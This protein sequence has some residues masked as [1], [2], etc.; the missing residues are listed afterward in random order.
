MPGSHQS[1]LNKRSEWLSDKARQW[2]VLG[3]IK[4]RSF[5]LSGKLVQD[6][7]LLHYLTQGGGE[8]F[9]FKGGICLVPD[10]TGLVFE[11]QCLVFKRKGLWAKLKKMVWQVDCC[12]PDWQIIQCRVKTTGGGW[13]QQMQAARISAHLHLFWN[14]NSGISVHLALLAWQGWFPYTGCNVAAP[15]GFH[16]QNNN[17]NNFSSFTE[18]R[19]DFEAFRSVWHVTLHPELRIQRITSFKCLK[20]P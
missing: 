11:R 3:L 12:V 8:G 16:P 9:L 5:S 18:R 10:F 1:S 4:I 17:N 6:T 14:S 13:L 15:R 20:A 7:R 2:S 19:T